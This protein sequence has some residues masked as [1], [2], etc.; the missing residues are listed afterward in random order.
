MT[1]DVAVALMPETVLKKQKRSEEWALLKKNEILER[2]KKNLINRKVMF[3]KA[4]KYAME[5]YFQVQLVQIFIAKRIAFIFCSVTFIR[6]FT[7]CY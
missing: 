4:E 1:G 3:K 2:R 5:Y 7:F 6:F